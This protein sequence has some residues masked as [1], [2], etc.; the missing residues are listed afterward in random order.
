MQQWKEKCKVPFIEIRLVQYS[1]GDFK[2][3]SQQYIAK[4]NTTI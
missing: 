1:E 2:P 4:I 3:L